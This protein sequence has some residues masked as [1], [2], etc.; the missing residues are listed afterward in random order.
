MEEANEEYEE[1]EQENNDEE[2]EELVEEDNGTAP[3]EGAQVIVDLRQN[4][5]QQQPLP[6]VVIHF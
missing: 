1:D 5:L 3:D 6:Q 2:E 4:R